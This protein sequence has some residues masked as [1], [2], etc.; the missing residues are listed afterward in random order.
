MKGYYQHLRDIAN[1]IEETR[2]KLFRDKEHRKN[3]DDLVDFE[4]C[5]NKLFKI[6]SDLRNLINWVDCQY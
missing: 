1:D 2:I 6:Q 5:D 4:E 3:L